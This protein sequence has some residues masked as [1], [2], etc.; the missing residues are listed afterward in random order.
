MSMSPS[1]PFF[2]TA[3]ELAEYPG[4][5]V[6]QEIDPVCRIALRDGKLTLIRLK[7]KPDTLR[8]ATR[9]VFT[10]EIGTIRFARGANHH[11]SGFILDAGRIQNFQFTRKTNQWRVT[12]KTLPIWIRRIRKVSVTHD[13]CGAIFGR[14]R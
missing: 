2:P 13:E 5:F 9:D 1:R 6:S 12:N 7:H 14:N 8:A 4:A 3:T 10:G 11:I